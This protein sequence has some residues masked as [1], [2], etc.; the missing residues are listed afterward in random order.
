MEKSFYIV[1]NCF[2]EYKNEVLFHTFMH[3]SLIL[4]KQPTLHAA[5][6]RVVLEFCSC[7]SNTYINLGISFFIISSKV[8]L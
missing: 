8:N 6:W 2:N 5:C 3:L 1:M 7:L 4:V